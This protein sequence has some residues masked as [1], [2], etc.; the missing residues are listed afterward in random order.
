MISCTE[1]AN[2][3]KGFYD[4][5][6]HAKECHPEKL[7]TIASLKAK[8]YNFKC[9]Q[10]N[11]NF[12]HKPNLN[13]HIKKGHGINSSLQK[14]NSSTK[15]LKKCALCEY[16]AMF[17]T[18]F[19]KH[20]PDVHN[21]RIETKMLEFVSLGDFNTWKGNLEKQSKT[22]FVKERGST[23]GITNYICRT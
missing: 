16:V 18:D 2:T 22:K 3:Y 17:K 6:K 14:T 1:C 19:Y 5:R 20:Y 4:L 15:R 12:S 9:S 7:A 8:N 13:F 23:Q 11:R 21:A 10:C